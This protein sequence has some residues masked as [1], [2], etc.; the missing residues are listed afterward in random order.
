MVANFKEEIIRGKRYRR[1]VISLTE[2]K[3]GKKSRNG[4]AEGR[5]VFESGSRFLAS[6]FVSLIW[7]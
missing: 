1:T 2:R 6:F 3:I 7:P 4:D 5:R